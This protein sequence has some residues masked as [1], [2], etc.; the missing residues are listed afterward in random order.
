MKIILT[1]EESEKHFYNALCNGSSLADCGSIDYAVKDYKAAKRNFKKLHS[2]ESPCLEDVWMQILRDG[3]SLRY[4]D[5]EDKDM[6]RTITLKM[7]HDRVAKTP[8]TH[9]VDAVNEN[10]DATT[11]YVIL[12]QVIFDEQIF[13]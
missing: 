2:G 1:K 11:A 5:H 6:N 12:Q 3:K 13:G 8:L 7:V 10:D 9:L 4:V